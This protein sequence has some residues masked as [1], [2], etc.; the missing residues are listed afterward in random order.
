LK[1]ERINA[2]S[3]FRVVICFK[4]LVVEKKEE[5]NFKIR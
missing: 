4:K 1:N 3:F 2:Q 5:K